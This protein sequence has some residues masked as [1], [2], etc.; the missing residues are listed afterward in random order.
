MA[1]VNKNCNKKLAAAFQEEDGAKPLC[2]ATT[3]YQHWSR[4][5]FTK[6]YKFYFFSAFSLTNILSL[7]SSAPCQLQP[8]QGDQLDS[9][10]FQIQM[11]FS[12]LKY[13]FL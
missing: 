8:T 4:R 12:K 1:I 5:E 13:I 6:L 2:E 11:Y 10:R 7:E 9:S 3:D